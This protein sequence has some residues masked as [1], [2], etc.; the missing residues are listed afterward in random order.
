MIDSTNYKTYGLY[1]LIILIG[2]TIIM[3][4][5]YYIV[6]YYGYLRGLIN[7]LS[8]KNLIFGRWGTCLNTVP[9]ESCQELDHGYIYGWCNDPDNYGP[10]PGTSDG[11]YVGSCSEWSWK[12]S[13]C[14]P[15]TCKG[16]YPY[17]IGNQKPYQKWGWCA[18]SGVNRAMK[19]SSCGPTTGQCVNWVWDEGQCIDVCPAKFAPEE[20]QEEQCSETILDSTVCG[21]VDGEAIACPPNRIKNR[22]NNVCGTVLDEDGNNV[23]QCP[24]PN[25]G[26]G[27]DKCICPQEKP[28]GGWKF[29]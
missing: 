6:G 9:R 11:P 28:P 14:P 26:C 20:Q 10:L 7:C 1:Y 18:D 8:F 23:L 27:S 19:G 29:F 16:C 13:T 4:T 25:C 24:P 12:K 2:A 17:G 15:A 22:C 3:Y 5:L 21:L